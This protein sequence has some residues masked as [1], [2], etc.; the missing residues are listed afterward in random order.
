MVTAKWYALRIFYG[1][2]KKVIRIKK[3]FDDEGIVTF[4]PMHYSDRLDPQNPG[5]PLKVPALK[6]LIMIKADERR[7]NEVMSRH[8]DD[9]DLRYVDFYRYRHGE[10][11][12]LP[13]EIPD[14]Q[15]QEFMNCVKENE[16]SL[17]FYPDDKLRQK[18]GRPVEVIAGQFKGIKG[19]LMRIEK[20]RH[21]V[22]VLPGVMGASFPHIP[23]SMLRF[24]E[25]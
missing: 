12:G 3:V 10:S 17:D 5:K 19:V 14:R 25:E 4:V 6:E 18:K 9:K 24:I 11:K 21:V 2:L 8:Q 20:N 7:C 16:D 15:M 13:I 23:V 1:G 22:I